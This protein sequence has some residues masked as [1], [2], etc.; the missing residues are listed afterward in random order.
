MIECDLIQD[1]TCGKRPVCRYC[2]GNMSGV[3]NVDIVELDG[4]GKAYKFEVVCYH[5]SEHPHQCYYEDLDLENRF[6]VKEGTKETIIKSD[7][8]REDD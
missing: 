7:K 1:E 4:Y 3:Q 6:I 8:Y 5:C 2:G